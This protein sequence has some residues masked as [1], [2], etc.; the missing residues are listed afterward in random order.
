MDYKKIIKSQKMRFKILDLLKIVPDDIM[1][2]T[3]YKIK[4]GRKL[5]LEQPNRFSEKLQWYKLNYRNNL[6]TKCAD[7]YAVREYI[8]EKGLENI[9][10]ENYG[11]FDKA[12]D[13]DFDVLPNKF[14]IKTTNGSATNFICKNKAKFNKNEVL[15]TLNEWSG[16]NIFASGREW[17]YKGIESKIIVEELLEDKSNGFDGINDYKIMCFNGKAEFVVLDVDRNIGHKRNIYTTKW[18]R[19]D[20]STDYPNINREIVKPQG[21]EEMIKIAEILSADFPFVRVDLY[22]VNEK[23]YFGELTFY[24]WTG[25]IQF[26]PDSF[27]YEMG[28]K[29]TYIN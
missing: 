5:N 28:K 15:Q 17:S 12:D 7:K 19:I 18:D 23:V 8:K 27:D 11:T 4:L 24:P 26:H 22:W 6:L 13:I 10:V 3:Q 2:K 25:Y 14:I 9:L 20:V 21:L 16:R 1:I 29:F